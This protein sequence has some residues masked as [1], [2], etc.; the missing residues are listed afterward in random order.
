MSK[1]YVTPQV[2]EGQ[3]E[4]SSCKKRVP[5]HEDGST[6]EAPVE[7]RPHGEHLKSGHEIYELFEDS[8]ID[9]IH[10]DD[11]DKPS[12]QQSGGDSSSRQ[13]GLLTKSL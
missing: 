12:T 4:W 2:G 8:F 6:N 13:K 7:R 9:D 5:P 11:C 1:E 3:Q 10:I